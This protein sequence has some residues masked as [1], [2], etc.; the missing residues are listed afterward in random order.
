METPQDRCEELLEELVFQ[1]LERCESGE[2]GVVEELCRLHPEQ[3]GELRRRID[4]LRASGLVGSAAGAPNRLGEFELV[5]RLGQGGMGVVY[6]AEQ[7]SLA[8]RV[9][10]KLVRPEQLFFAGARERFRREVEAVA[11]LAHPGIVPVFSVG[12]QDGLPYYA[13]ELVEGVSLDEVVARLKGR[14]PARLEG[15]DLREAIV[16]LCRERGFDVPE[17]AP[18]GLPLVG[19]WPDVCAWIVR[20]VAQALE[21]AHQRGVLHRDVKPSNVLVTPTGRVM[22]VDFGLA[23]TAGSERITGQGAQLGSFAYMSPEALAGDAAIDARSDV[24]GLGATYFELLTLRLPFEG[25]SSEQLRL[26]Q[27][28]PSP[29][30]HV[31]SL[32]A[33][34]EIVVATALDPERERRY[35]SA[36]DFAR[37]LSH[38]LARRPVEARAIG[39]WLALRRWSQRRPAAATAAAL[40]LVVAIAAPWA[41][42]VQEAKARKQIEHERDLAEAARV[43]AETA[44]QIA[45]VEGEAARAAEQLATERGNL[46]QSNLSAA[47]DAIE[48][49]LTQVGHQDLRDVPRVESLRRELLER[50]TALYA[51]IEQGAGDDPTVKLR[52]AVALGKLARLRRDTGDTQGAV[53]DFD[54]A[55]ERL[56]ALHAADPADWRVCTEL[57]A[58]IAFASVARPGLRASEAVGQ[59]ERSLE[60]LRGAVER[61]PAERRPRAGL[62]RA[63]LGLAHFLDAAGDRTRARV[64]WN[65]AEAFSLVLRGED[66]NDPDALELWVTAAGRIATIDHLAGELARAQERLER[67]A[68]ETEGVREPSSFLRLTRALSVHTQ[69]R[70]LMQDPATARDPRVDPWLAQSHAELAALAADFPRNVQHVSS[71]LGI[72]LDLVDRALEAGDV[73]G[74]ATLADRGW[75]TANRAHALSPREPQRQRG[76][77]LAAERLHDLERAR[78][79]LATART[80]A[81]RSFEESRRAAEAGYRPAGPDCARML[82]EVI[83]CDSLLGDAPGLIASA[84]A[85]AQEQARSADGPLVL[86]DAAIALSFAAGL[87]ERAGDSAR[88]SAL[89]AEAAGWLES[90]VAARPEL[91]QRI[92]ELGEQWGSPAP[93]EIQS[94]LDAL[95]R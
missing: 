5:R 94:V 36:A 77:G 13:M 91:A 90:A 73:G 8:R 35:A 74:A 7:P 37:D 62:A 81:Q 58:L 48:G 12:E 11:R 9:A 41:Y 61:A 1:V 64:C 49:L 16:E 95:A 50:A 4:S 54:R 23:S 6:V 67:I 47:L 18:E 27:L 78:G 51:R 85:L 40:G 59:L 70:I 66:P 25:A 29:R 79:D 86:V 76:L 57:G 72:E 19:A 63:L 84:R 93:P 82:R 83:E 45:K 68:S 33:D 75:A 42:G 34:V 31:A 38:L 26:R 55:L 65:E 60:L 17:R 71:L 2:T 3:S 44:E 43:R 88:T 53:A 89:C 24:F 69:A 87:L 56:E 22:L 92:L 46:A 15:G 32:G 10:L 20:E 21:H 52:S 14:E 39:P 30:R 80:W 28:P